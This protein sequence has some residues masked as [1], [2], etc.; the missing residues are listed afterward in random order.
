MTSRKKSAAA[1]AVGPAPDRGGAWI[2]Q[3]DGSLI[4]DPDEEQHV[5]EDEAAKPLPADAEQPVPPAPVPPADEA[6]EA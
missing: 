2:R 4:R 3:A 1:P 5:P 6:Q